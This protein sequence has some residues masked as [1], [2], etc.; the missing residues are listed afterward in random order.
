MS[1]KNVNSRVTARAWLRQN[2]Y[3]D[4][5]DILDAYLEHLKAIGSGERRNYWELLAGNENG[6]RATRHKFVF[7][8]LES[9][10]KARRPHYK[11]S[12]FAIKR[13]KHEKVPAPVVQ[14]RWKNR[15]K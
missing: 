10:R 12:K 4:V 8:I 13:N 6:E 1:D 15:N 5:A 11:P 7:P 3:N 9:V 2:G 14:E